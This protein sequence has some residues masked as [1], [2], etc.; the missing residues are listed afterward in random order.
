[1]LVVVPAL[2]EARL[3]GRAVRSARQG[4]A[5]AVVVVDGGSE[6]DT[7]QVRRPSRAKG[8]VFGLKPGAYFRVSFSFYNGTVGILIDRLQPLTL[9]DV[10]YCRWRGTRGRLWRSWQSVGGARSR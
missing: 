8:D 7:V 5:D 1:M 10:W 6:D 2:N 4:G 9:P 3:V